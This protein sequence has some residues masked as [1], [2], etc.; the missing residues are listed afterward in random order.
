[1]DGFGVRKTAL[2]M[3]NIQDFWKYHKAEASFLKKDKSKACF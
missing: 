3:K 2:L 1:M